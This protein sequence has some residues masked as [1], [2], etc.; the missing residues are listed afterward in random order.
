MVLHSQLFDVLSLDIF[1]IF[2]GFTPRIQPF[3]TV[4]FSAE[5]VVD[6]TVK[7]LAVMGC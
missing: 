4:F 2:K 6:V 1:S 7:L 3:I 5:V